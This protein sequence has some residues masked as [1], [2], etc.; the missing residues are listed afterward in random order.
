MPNE[1]HGSFDLAIIGAGSAGFAAAIKAA[2]LGARVAL[3]EG[4]TLGGTCVNVGCV[5]SKTLIRAA[6]AQYRRTH[7][8]FEGIAKS[9]GAPDWADVRMQKDALVS[10][11]RQSKYWDVL[12]AYD[13]ITLFQ[14]RA[15]LTTGHDAQLGDGR[16]VAAE[17]LIVTTGS[18]PWLP[19][20][21]GLAEASPL[22]NAAAMALDRL[23]ASMI[24]IGGSAVGVE[25]A[26]MFARLGVAITILEALSHLVPSE[27]SE[28]GV[29]LADHLRSEG[30]EIH[31]GVSITGVESDRASRTVTFR[32]QDGE[33]HSVRA[34][35]VLVATGRRANTK[36]FGLEAAGVKLGTKREVV[37]DEFLATSNPRIYAAGDVLGDPMFVYVAAY[38]GAVAAENALSGNVR[39][40]DITAV[41]RVTFSDPA[42]ASV[43]LTDEE[44]RRRGLE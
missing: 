44:A 21:P 6:E 13:S 22:D 41:P 12:R 32:D 5:P 35:R 15:T 37:V 14:Q 42:V 9:D 7:H 4:G 3:I 39:R 20:I 24:V 2:E 30:L 16:S 10:S 26:Q 36:G 31:V 17:G 1:L 25:L 28:I 18:S 19:P 33:A 23:P 43:G 8:P 34:E 27:D 38:A 40:Y 11:L 29:G